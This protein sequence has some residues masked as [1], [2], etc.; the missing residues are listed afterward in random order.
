MEH[1]TETFPQASQRRR[2]RVTDQHRSVQRRPLRGR[3]DSDRVLVSAMHDAVKRFP[4]YG[5]RRIR[6]ELLKQGLVL[7]AK[8]MYRLWRESG[9]SV[10]RKRKRRRGE[11][12]RW[13]RE[14]ATAPNQVWT[15]DFVHDVDQRGRTLRWLALSDEFT[16]ELLVFEPRRRFP[17]RAVQAELA[18]VMRRRGTPQRL[19]SD[20]GPEFTAAQLRGLLSDAGVCARTIEPGKPWQNGKAEGLNSR[21]R[22]EFF[23]MEHFADLWDARRK[24]SA[25]QAHY[26]RDRPHSALGYRSPAE[27]AASLAAPPVGAS[28]LPPGQPASPS[29]P[30]LPSPPNSHKRWT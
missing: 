11:G 26:N 9:F 18:R 27:F 15:W 22:D 23:E 20:N 14:P 12:K 2:C 28:P 5:Y 29:P 17:A 6:V 7:G 10:P 4:R 16:R 24:G 21:L 8:K 13:P 19:R 25:F 1:L 30:T 3:S